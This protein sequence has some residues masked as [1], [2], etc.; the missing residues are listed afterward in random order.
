MRIRCAH[1]VTALM[2][3]LLLSACGG[4][5]RIIPRSTLANIYADMFLADQW[6]SDH[7]PERLTAD[8]TL[9]YDPIFARYGYT[10]EDYDYSVKH[11]LK[12]PERFSKIFRDAADKLKK[13][14]DIYVS[15]KEF[16]EKVKEFNE[17]I[18]GY[19]LVDFDHDSLLWKRP[20][21]D[22]LILDSLR[23]DS[24]FRDSVRR[25]AL[26]LDSLRLDSLYR[27]SAQRHKA[28]IDSALN[29]QRS[30]RVNLEN[31]V[32]R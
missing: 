24:L 29:R 22:S 16:V 3:I 26:R 1:M 2:L 6:L 30:R 7:S 9:F 19:S 28:R 15:K 17:G 13:E 12:D 31:Q 5:A 21:T 18:R 10:F 23:R 32:N 11:Y 27:D 8:T 4:R 25:E 14:R 20:I